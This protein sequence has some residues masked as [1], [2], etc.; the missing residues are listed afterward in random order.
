MYLIRGQKVLL[1]SDLAGLY[2]VLPKALNQAV[3]EM[4]IAFLTTSYS[5]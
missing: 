4:Q 1:A 3:K 2:G 5:N